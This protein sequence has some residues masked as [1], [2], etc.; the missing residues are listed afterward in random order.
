LPFD[1][2]SFDR[3]Y[4]MLVLQ[5]IPNA[6]RAVA[7]MRRVVRSGGTVT[8]AVWDS[9]GGMPQ[10]RMI[11][12]IAAVLDTALERP[13]LRAFVSPGELAEAWRAVGLVDVN[14]I[15]LLIR[16]EY[17]CFDDYW[18]PMT[19]EGPVASYIKTLSGSA[20]ANLERHVRH[21]YCANRSDGPRSFA[22]VAWACRG[23]VPR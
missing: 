14:Q 20:F 2:A 16:V 21:A 4:S 17:D 19:A 11:W 8:A 6:I 10:V 18:L 7:E 5:F 22:N 9:Y 12:D 3:T 15:N 23:T 13:L 1:D